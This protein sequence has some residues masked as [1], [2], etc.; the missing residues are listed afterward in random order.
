LDRAALGRAV[1]GKPEALK[2]LERIVHPLVAE[3][4]A[5]FLRRHRQ[6]RRPFV[7]LDVPLLFERG[8]WRRVDG[9]VVVSAPRHVQRARV[10][11]RPGMT[12]EK[13][14]AILAAQMPDREKRS[15]AD[16]VIPTG[17]GRRRSLL[18]VRR[19]S[20]CLSR[21]GVRYCRQCAKS[22]LTPKRRA[23]TPNRATASAR[24]VR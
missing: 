13:F 1:F 24:S 10:L 18:A 21:A 9:I 15:R 23:S 19:L 6:A 20:A 17:L 2:T 14:A 22:S 4:Q 11:A 7:L 12:A 5:A 16:F 3:A 8:G